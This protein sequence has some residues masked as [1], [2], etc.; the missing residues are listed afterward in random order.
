MSP[1][2]VEALCALDEPALAALAHFEELSEGCFGAYFAALRRALER[3]AWN[4]AS[5]DIFFW[6]AA[7]LGGAFGVLD[8][9]LLGGRRQ[10]IAE[11]RNEV[12]ELERIESLPGSRSAWVERRETEFRQPGLVATVWRLETRTRRELSLVHARA[13][14]VCEAARGVMRNASFIKT[15]FELLYLPSAFGAHLISRSL[16]YARANCRRRFSRAARTSSSSLA[17]M[18]ARISAM[19]A[20]QSVALSAENSCCRS[21]VNFSKVRYSSSAR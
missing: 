10:V 14:V 19:G 7:P 6:T 5:R 8:E 3:C 9:E 1:A 18:S 11:F 13:K 17:L 12:A 2:Q 15:L 4:K 20:N 21:Y 16:R